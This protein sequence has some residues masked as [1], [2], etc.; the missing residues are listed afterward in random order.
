MEQIQP[1]GRTGRFT[2]QWLP[3]V[4]AA[5]ALSVYLATLNHW[6]ST[7]SLAYAAT[8]SGWSSRPLLI[9]P[10][11]WLVTYPFRWLPEAAI[12]LALNLLS[13]V[14][15]AL[16]LALLAR[17]VALLPHDRTQSQRL[18]ETGEFSLLSVRGA[19]LPP[20][21]A[22]LLCG[23]ELT[24]WENATAASGEMLDLLAFAY[25]IRCL[26]EFRLEERESWLTRAAFAYG[27][28]MT[29]NWTMIGFL[30]VFLAS[31]VWT[32]GLGFFD[33]R[34]LTRMFLCGLCGMVL[35]LLLPLT[36]SLG[37]DAAVSF[38]QA[39]KANLGSQ[40]GMVLAVFQH[41][42]HELL[43]IGLTSLLPVLIIGIRWAPSFGDSN[44]LGVALAT[45]TFHVVHALFLGAC[46]WVALDPPFSPRNLSD[47]GFPSL[48]AYYLGALAV[49]YLSGYFLLVFRKTDSRSADRSR[50]PPPWLGLVNALATATVCVLVPATGAVLLG[51]NLP[52]IRITN[53]PWLKQYAS[54]LDQK[55]PAHN[56][57]VLGD[58]SP[59][60][61]LLRAL[62]VQSSAA[63]DCLL[64][65]TSLLR[66]PSYHPFLKRH[67]P[68]YW[69]FDLPK[70][71][72][73]L[74][75]DATL[76]RDI[77]ALA[78][79]NDL[80]YLYPSFGYY[81]EYFYL[82][83]HGVVYKLDRYA[84]NSLLAPPLEQ[85]VVDENQTFWERAG[86][87]LVKP[88]AAAITPAVP[89][90]KP[91]LTERLRARARLEAMANRE[92]LIL[93]AWYARDLDYW[94]VELQKRGQWEPAARQFELAQELNPD[95]RAAQLNLRCNRRLRAGTAP[96][97]WTVPSDED[98]FGPEIRNN[99]SQALWA[100][101]PYD[102]PTCCYRLGAFYLDATPAPQVRQA[103]A[104]FERAVALAPGNLDARLRLG[105]LYADNN[106]PDETLKLVAPIR[107]DPQRFG[108]GRTNEAPVLLVEMSALLAKKDAPAAKALVQRTVSKYPG[109]EEMLAAAT[110]VYVRNGL[111]SNALETVEQQLQISPDD[112]T[113]LYVKAYVCLYL[114]AF[115]QA[116]PAFTKVLGVQ[117]NNY[118]ALRGRAGAYL[119][120]GQW[121]AARRDY[122]GMIKLAP[123]D[124]LAHYG[125]GEAAYKQK[126]TNT[127]IKEYEVFLV[128]A[129]TNSTQ[130]QTIAARVKELKAGPH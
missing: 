92:A 95:N 16:T 2:R 130:A 30:P 98:I 57:V 94:G 129:P 97:A 122:E 36:Q 72:D 29:N 85:A 27:L 106:M 109:D 39:L 10:L 120:S 12:P 61:W 23:L 84:T 62:Q 123:T 73:H 14:C 54:F 4:I 38:W 124:F 88:L 93:G 76:I 37:H 114:R 125:L 33:L 51:R 40:T 79:H 96:D 48:P 26:L 101:G 60:L 21:L 15:A 87:G 70:D 41:R 45:F 99:W 100:N 127:A 67:F 42:R 56:V 28:A 107:G 59:R 25:V 46:V 82:E 9:Q 104:Q 78:Q 71:R 102:E 5:G 47:W 113:T 86:A 110:S 7:G 11:Y 112:P 18:R 50:R 90:A 105:Q 22:V 69:T 6:V 74:V 77:Y 43:A 66:L 65:D 55:L 34:F 115:D 13:A 116:I 52:Q 111:Y 32:K 17:S 118:G 31:L 89:K 24:F 49:G 8:V 20:V 128:G 80:Y 121:D 63:K 119:S 108:L 53:G 19:W 35:Y 44:P 91:G 1:E 103:A 81:F 75:P 126:D 64:L 83:P 58:D 117:T 68:K 3:W